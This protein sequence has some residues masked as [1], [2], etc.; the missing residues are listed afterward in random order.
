[1]FIWGC[2]KYPEDN[3][4]SFRTIKNRV[5]SHPWRIKHYFIDGVDYANNTFY[6]DGYDYCAGNGKEWK[7]SQIK[8]TYTRE[9]LDATKDE[10]EPYIAKIENAPRV[11]GYW[12]WEF[13]THKKEFSGIPY[14]CHTEFGHLTRAWKIENLTVRKFVVSGITNLNKTIRIELEEYR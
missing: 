5:T 2:K 8:L 11:Q 10:K 1:V 7:Y 9:M 6:S 14:F 3:L 13:R 12:T 4:I